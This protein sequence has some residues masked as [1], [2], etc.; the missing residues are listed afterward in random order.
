MNK[1]ILG[2]IIVI[3]SSIIVYSNTLKNSFQW[4]DEQRIVKNIHI[5]YLKNIPNFFKPGY[6]N[7]YEEARGERYRPLRTITFAIDYKFW[8][9]NSVGYHITNILLH[10]I[11]SVLVW[12]FVFYITKNGLISTLSALV[13]AVHP[14]HTETVTYIKN[15]SDVLCCV[16]YL[17]SFMFFT[18]S[19]EKRQNLIQK[20][21]ASLPAGEE[22]G[23]A[24]SLPPLQ[25]SCPPTVPCPP[26]VQW[27]KWWGRA[28]SMTANST[29][30]FLISFLFFIL[31]IL[32][33]E[34]AVTIPLVFTLYIVFFIN[35]NSQKSALFKTSYF[36][37]LLFIYVIFRFYYLSGG[38]TLGGSGF[39]FLA[40]VRTVSDY[41][42]LSFIPYPLCLDRTYI[43]YPF[44][45][46]TVISSI[47]IL[48]VFFVFILKTN[49][50]SKFFLIFFLITL[51]PV[52]NILFIKER[53]IAEQ[54]LYIPS[55][56]LCVFIGIFLATNF[57]KKYIKVVF[58]LILILFSYLTVKRNN[59]Y[60][61]EIT[62]WRKT[63]KTSPSSRAFNNLGT[64]YWNKKY[65]S[66]AIISWKNAIKL[67]NYNAEA[68]SNLGAVS[69]DLKFYDEAI[70][71]F[72]K[73]IE[74]EPWNYIVISNLGAA[75]SIKGDYKN[76]IEI[77]KKAVEI[78]PWV[79]S[80]H[81]NL[82]VTYLRL[83]NYE[84]SKKEFDT[85]LL[86]D[87]FHW[88]SY[89]QLSEMFEKFGKKDKAKELFE[90]SERIRKE[91]D[92]TNIQNK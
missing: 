79:A 22:G 35:K 7:L 86:Y 1:N 66:D 39:N 70:E 51:L 53:A 62:L 63:I 6:F 36:W 73:A 4:D 59:D 28:G 68:I 16:F 60:R 21:D 54:R 14:V 43:E 85:A 44:F 90:K 87:P 33:K 57:S 55:I 17:L 89:V 80:N 88:Q 82:G 69:Y 91:L 52:S 13:F 18:R 58:L 29:F 84:D 38:K 41:I 37:F 3:V 46:L 71:Y 65:Y 5:R 42:K 32:S 67:D 19:I 9:N 8:K 92:I 34:M 24:L 72:K 40:I 61:D 56:G 15:R 30:N 78:A 64:A 2:I 83:K 20:R 27:R 25:L 76:A 45:S 77:H 74:I 31:A 11:C 23:Q 48:F 81:Y 49:R 50:Q 12:Y 47:V 26:M 10:T 75:Y